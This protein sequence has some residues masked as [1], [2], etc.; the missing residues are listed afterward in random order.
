MMTMQKVARN[1]EQ[2]PKPQ[3]QVAT[4]NASLLGSYNK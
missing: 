2:V 4:N 3:Q 1:L